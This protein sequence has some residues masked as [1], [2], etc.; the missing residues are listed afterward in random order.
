MADYFDEDL[1][2]HGQVELPYF[3]SWNNPAI[4]NTV[5]VTLLHCID[6]KFYFIDI[7]DDDKYWIIL[8]RVKSRKT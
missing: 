7:R 1:N 3:E 2:Y 6:R 4:G 8:W 5:V